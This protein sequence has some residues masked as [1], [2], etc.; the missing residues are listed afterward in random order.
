MEK[1]QKKT[2]K[3]K[4]RGEKEKKEESF[5]FKESDKLSKRRQVYK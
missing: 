4:I 5:F 2:P 1:T 3:Q